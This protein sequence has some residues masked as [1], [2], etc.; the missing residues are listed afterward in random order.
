M[1]CWVANTG[2]DMLAFA[3]LDSFSTYIFYTM[4]FSV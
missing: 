4:S 3:A 2:K 1:S